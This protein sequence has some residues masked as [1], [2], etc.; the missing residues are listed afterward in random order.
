MYTFERQAS[1]SL[2]V[3]ISTPARADWQNRA[4]SGMQSLFTNPHTTRHLE[5]LWMQ[6]A[7][8][9]HVTI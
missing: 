7:L 3:Y 8:L 9:R 1:F 5:N 2:K 4:S 6:D